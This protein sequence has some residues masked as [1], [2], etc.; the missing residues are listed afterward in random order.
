MIILIDLLLTVFV[1]LFFP[2]LYRKIKG[3]VPHKKAKKISL[4]NAIVC[5][6]AFEAFRI[7]L[8]TSVLG[9][10]PSSV[11]IAPAFLY[12]FIGV[13]ILEEKGSAKGARGT[14]GDSGE[15]PAPRSL[16]HIDDDDYP[17]DLSSSDDSADKDE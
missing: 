16:H 15:R 6:V 8:Y 5:A 4:I 12:Y 13:S 3:R 10:M 14:S 11:G 2:F 17:E 9:E 1:Y 7:I